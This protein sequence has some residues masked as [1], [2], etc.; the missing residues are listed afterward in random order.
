MLGYS[1]ASICKWVRIWREQARLGPNPNG[2]RK[3]CFS[4]DELTELHELLDP[5]HDV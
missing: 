5:P 3:S 2:H 4:P 1:P